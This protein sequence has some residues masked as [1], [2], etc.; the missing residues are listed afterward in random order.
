LN[1]LKAVFIGNR[2]TVYD[3]A[4]ELGMQI[5]RIF[6]SPGS[7]LEMQLKNNGTDYTSLVSKHELIKQLNATQYDI[8]ISNGCPYVLPISQLN[9]GHKQFI[10]IHPS[11][12]PDL[13]GINPINGAVLYNRPLG[14]TCHLMDDG[15]DT[16]DIISSIPVKIDAGADIGLMYQLA[17][18]AEADAFRVAYANNFAPIQQHQSDLTDLIYYSRKDSD[19]IIDW[20]ETIE[21]IVRRVK[22]FSTPSQLSRFKFKNE[23]Y[24]V[25]H[26]EIVQSSFIENKFKAIPNF[27][28]VIKY[29]DTLIIK[30][31]DGYL[32][33]FGILGNIDQISALET[34][35]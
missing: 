9:D 22:A 4:V 32:K 8:L 27:S 28:V 1:K 13:R 11:L 5:T 25:M 35:T 6:A 19:M 10:N 21:C 24:K 17:F 3:V 31:P 33:L 20:N 16:G 15:V 18:M 14:A 29:T 7:Y 23:S 26:A 30:L 12:L 2:S 34:L